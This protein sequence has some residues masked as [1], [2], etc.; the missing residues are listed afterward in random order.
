[1][2]LEKSMWEFHVENRT[3]WVLNTADAQI[4]SIILPA[5]GHSHILYAGYY[6]QLEQFYYIFIHLMIPKHLHR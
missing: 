5:V 3:L 6:L 2:A 4:D 1:M